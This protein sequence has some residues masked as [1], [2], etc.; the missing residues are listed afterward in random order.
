MLKKVTRK[1]IRRHDIIDSQRARRFD[2]ARRP[3]SHS[4]ERM[5]EATIPFASPEQ[6]PA[7][8]GAQDRYLRLIRDALGI[9]VTYRDDELRLRG[10]EDQVKR[11]QEVFEELQSIV[12]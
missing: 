4:V 12:E 2:A 8:F 10:N 1:G 6:L 5:S 3:L 7:L 11:A 9:D